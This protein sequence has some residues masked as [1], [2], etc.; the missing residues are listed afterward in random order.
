VGPKVLIHLIG[1][2]RDLALE[3]ILVTEVAILLDSLS[4]NAMDLIHFG[5]L[6]FTRRSTVMT[7]VVVPL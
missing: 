3:V 2:K 1:K 6:V 7:H 4:G 5:D